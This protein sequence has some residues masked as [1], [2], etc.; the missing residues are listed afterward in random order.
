VLALMA[1]IKDAVEEGCQ[2]IVS[3]HSPILMA[4]PG[5]EILLLKDGCVAPVPYDEIEHVQFTRAFLNDPQKY[6]RHV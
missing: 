1:L 3:T 5:A 6:L 2:F 4:Q